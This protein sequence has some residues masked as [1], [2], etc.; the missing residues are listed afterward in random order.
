M[1]EV[2]RDDVEQAVGVLAPAG[3]ARARSHGGAAG[4][5]SVATIER[6]DLQRVVVVVGEV[7]DD[8]GG[9]RVHVAAAEL[10]GA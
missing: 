7:V 1:R 5:G 10:L 4:G 8:A 6:S 9:A 3:A 2:E